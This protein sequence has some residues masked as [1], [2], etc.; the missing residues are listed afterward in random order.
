MSLDRGRGFNFHVCLSPCEF[1]YVGGGR[2]Y[3]ILD[4]D[5]KSFEYE[6]KAIGKI[7]KKI[8]EFPFP[9]TLEPL[10]IIKKEEILSDNKITAAW[11]R[12]NSQYGIGAN[13]I[14]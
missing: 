9:A 13:M 14:G 2:P 6:L 4:S 12:L 5:R 3:Y 7:S 8:A 1:Q 10:H 11:K